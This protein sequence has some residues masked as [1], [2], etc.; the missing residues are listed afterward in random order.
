MSV[1]RI[2]VTREVVL[3]APSSAAKGALPRP[4]SIWSMPR[5]Q[6]FLSH[7]AAGLDRVRRRKGDASAAAPHPCPRL[8]FYVRRRRGAGAAGAPGH[9]SPPAAAV[10]KGSQGGHRSFSETTDLFSRDYLSPLRHFWDLHHHLRAA[11][12]RPHCSTFLVRAKPFAQL[13]RSPFLISRI[14]P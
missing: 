5:N 6:F 11:L 1:L 13:Q 7:T 9:S 14:G 12:T 2:V 10:A 3:F 4:R 8:R